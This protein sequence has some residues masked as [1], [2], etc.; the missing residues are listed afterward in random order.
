MGLCQEDD[1]GTRAQHPQ[2]SLLLVPTQVFLALVFIS[3]W[4]TV[5]VVGSLEARQTR[6]TSFIGQT[7]K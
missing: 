6:A 5:D 3:I 7:I 4:L 2:E 1:S